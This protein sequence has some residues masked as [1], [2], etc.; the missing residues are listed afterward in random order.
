MKTKYRCEWVGAT[1]LLVVLVMIVTA[2]QLADADGLWYVIIFGDDGADC[3]SP[4]T[5]C[6][7]INGAIE[8]AVSGDTVFVAAGTYTGVGA[9]VVLIDRDITLSGGWDPVFSAQNGRSIIDGQM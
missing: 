2:F 9:E 8:K 4:V 3:A 1:S 6:A 5:A 7:T